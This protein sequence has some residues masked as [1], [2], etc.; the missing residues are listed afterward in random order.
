[1]SKVKYMVLFEGTLEILFLTLPLDDSSNVS[2]FFSFADLSFNSLTCMCTCT[3]SI[4]LP[5][6]LLCPTISLNV[7]M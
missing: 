6:Y 1:M 3:H 2:L 7:S 5:Y 4:L